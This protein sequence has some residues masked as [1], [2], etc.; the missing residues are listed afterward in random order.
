M[1]SMQ[2][3]QEKTLTAI[4][5]D[6]ASLSSRSPSLTFA[7]PQELESWR[8]KRKFLLVVTAAGETNAAPVLEI[9][10]ILA[11]RG[12]TV[13]F[14]TLR[15]REYWATKHDF[16]SKIHILGPEIT[17]EEDEV[18]YFNVNKW[19]LKGDF[20]AVV[21]CRKFLEESWP[22]VYAA[23][24]ILVTDPN[25]RPDFILADYLVDA[26]RDMSFEYDIPI[27]THWPQMPTLMCPCPYIPGHAGLQLDALTSENASMWQRVK[28]E[29]VLV[30]AL[31][32]LFD[33]ML[34]QRKRRQAAGVE[35]MLPML[36]KP[37]NLCLINSCFGMEKP[38]DLPPFVAAVGP[39]LA[40]SYPPLTEDL[41]HF[42]DCR[43]RVLYIALGSHVILPNERFE[44]LMT[45]VMKAMT[46]GL[47]DG[48]IWSIREVARKK[49]DRN[50]VLYDKHGRPL[51]AGDL[52]D[53]CVADWAVLPW[54]PQRAV[55][56]H[57][58]LC[59]YL[60]HG[61]ASSTNEVIYHGIPAICLGVYFDQLA[62]AIRMREAGVAE[63]LERDT[64]T[65][66][67]VQ[68][69]VEKIIHDEGGH[70]ERN[71]K[72]MKYVA[73]IAS[74]RKYLAAD[75]IEEVLFDHE[76]RGL[77]GPNPRPMHLQ[78]A[79]MRM[80]FF[81]ARNWDMYT[82]IVIALL[83]FFGIVIAM[84]VALAKKV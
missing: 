22:N 68:A 16:V 36:R 76:G 42:L 34:W 50:H 63:T 21:Q 49:L 37:N 18:Q 35:R 83:V 47:I 64:F 70:I 78:T 38:K 46:N 29:L 32:A 9:G 45:G 57:P 58:H 56:D 51:T 23:L 75:L 72:R 80:G 40:D 73:R 54:V 20:S 12:H 79:D 55:L 2:S 65:A 28:S 59:I 19:S 74:R 30:R 82:V 3:P 15:G 6:P 62:Y 25:T 48:V 84:P 13:E 61:G 77:E 7:I 44:K 17:A 33:Y 8:P 5:V 26:A 60:T 43:E 14:G 53:G 41:Q 11:A 31:P 39:I 67:Q 71:V 4:N 27:A 24:K 52:L 66:D 81:K 1:T 69:K 10:R